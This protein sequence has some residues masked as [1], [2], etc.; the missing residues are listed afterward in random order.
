MAA[1]NL[2]ATTTV[3]AAGA[4][5]ITFSNIPQTYT[6][7][8]LKVSLRSIASGTYDAL[9]VFLNGVQ[10]D[11]T[12][13]AL[14]GNGSTVSSNTSTY[15]DLGIVNG[16]TSTANTFSNIELYFPNYTSANFKSI[17]SD[18]VWETNGAASDIAIF[19]GLWSSTSAITTILLD[20]AS[21]GLSY[22]QH[23]SAS[24]YGIKN[25]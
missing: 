18:S 6:D 8:L 3:G 21:S 14:I 25:S 10:T 13:R 4:S 1:Y 7:L 19:A 16:N 11:R 23:S 17:S 5:G 12:R 2:I 9:G 15:R 20:N 24:L 22:M